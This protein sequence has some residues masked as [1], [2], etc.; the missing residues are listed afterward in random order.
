[1]DVDTIRKLLSGEPNYVDVDACGMGAT[2]ISTD[3]FKSIERPWFKSD[4]L[5]IS[6]DIYFFDQV[7]KAGFKAVA[8]IDKTMPAYHHMVK[9]VV[10]TPDGRLALIG[11]ARG[12]NQSGQQVI[13][14]KV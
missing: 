4:N 2:L 1:M 12:T 9:D 10:L 7:K 13:I 5:G 14:N 6:E 11:E 3:V 8:Y